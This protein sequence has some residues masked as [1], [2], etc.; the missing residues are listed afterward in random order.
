M[1]KRAESKMETSREG[2]KAD[3]QKEEKRMRRNELGG[4]RAM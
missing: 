3:M 1:I 2:G 4:G